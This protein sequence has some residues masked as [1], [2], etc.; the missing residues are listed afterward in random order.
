MNA[1]RLCT[2]ALGVCAIMGVLAGCG[3]AQT[4]SPAGSTL[5]SYANPSGKNARVPLLYVAN[6]ASSTVKFLR[7]PENGHRHVL[8]TV[9]HPEG[10]CSD[11]VGHVFVTS[12]KS[13]NNGE[14]VEFPHASSRRIAT[15]QDRDTKPMACAVDTLTG[16][17]AVVGG[18]STSD[19]S[20][21]VA[22]YAAAQGKPTIYSDPNLYSYFACAYDDAG[23]LY[24]EG[25]NAG[26]AVG[27]AELPKGSQGLSSFSI[28]QTMTVAG[29][30]AWD[31]TYLIVG[32]NFSASNHF[33]IYQV[34]ISGSTGTVANTIQLDG[35][36]ITGPLALY[37][38]PDSKIMSPCYG[39]DVCIWAYPAGN[40]WLHAVNLDNGA[41]T[42]VTVSLPKD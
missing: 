28:N 42:G 2:Q 17:L 26:G 33:D 21:N 4:G 24:V 22:V 16:N 18:P 32:G 38:G 40:H 35:G 1:L 25:T 13:R 14:I 36:S 5:A 29:G 27:F 3:G 8:E 6:A 37:S 20:G 23:N 9:P 11:S 31:G 34:S 30:I 10:L 39:T 7:F 12:G 41:N 19:K 15:L